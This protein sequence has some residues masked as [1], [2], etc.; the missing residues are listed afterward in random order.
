MGGSKKKHTTIATDK[1]NIHITWD[2]SHSVS[3]KVIR[4]DEIVEDNSPKGAPTEYDRIRS[5]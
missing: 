4:E 5:L 3:F 1:V 2:Y